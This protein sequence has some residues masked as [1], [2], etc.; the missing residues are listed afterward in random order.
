VRTALTLAPFCLVVFTLSFIASLSTLFTSDLSTIDKRSG[1]GYNAVVTSSP[2][3]PIPFREIAHRTG[4]KAMAELARVDVAY[5]AT[6]SNHPLAAPV[7]GFDK[8]FIAAGRAP[9]LFNRGPFKTDAAAYRAVLRDADLIIVEPGFLNRYAAEHVG[10][11]YVGRTLTIIDPITTQAREVQVAAVVNADI[12]RNG[13]FYG[14]QALKQLVGGRAVTNRAYVSLQ[15]PARFTAAV[16]REFVANGAKVE[17]LRVLGH[18]IR[19]YV[20][21]LVNVYWTYLGV[22]LVVGVAGVAVMMVRAVR[23]RRRQIGVLR[24]IGFEAGMV[25][26]GFMLEAAFVAV[27]AVVLGVG[28]A[29]AT[30][31]SI[32]HSAELRDFLGIA[33]HFTIAV[34]ALTTLAGVTIVAAL[35]ATAGPARSAS[36]IPPSEALRLVD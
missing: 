11:M 33:P 29:V 3:N 19:D 15:Q 1:G 35:L 14:K 13:A 10:P 26:R 22:G 23:E 9:K 24:A 5:I 8:E 34:G 25:G 27:Q 12:A 36:N 7:T 20:V 31:F 18:R 2:V 30:V 17:T 32:T 21:Q 28:L 6:P 4:V 16:Q